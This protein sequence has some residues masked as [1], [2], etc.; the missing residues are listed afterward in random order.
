MAANFL[1]YISITN[2]MTVLLHVQ[3]S[4]ASG[5]N[6]TGKKLTIRLLANYNI[7]YHMDRL[8]SR[9]CVQ[10]SYHDT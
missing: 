9:S 7:L 3:S 2:L 5:S 10:C 6:I 1:L 4:Y 8:Y